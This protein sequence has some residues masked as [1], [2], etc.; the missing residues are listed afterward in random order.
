MN[1]VEATYM[2]WINIHGLGIEDPVKFFKRWGYALLMVQPL[3][4]PDL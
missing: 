2:G 1:H 4:I 3:A